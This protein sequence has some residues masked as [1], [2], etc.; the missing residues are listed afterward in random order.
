MQRV[1]ASRAASAGLAAVVLCLAAFSIFAAYTTRI[2]IDQAARAQALAQSYE[3]GIGV[4]QT[5][6]RLKLR[7]FLDPS[8]GSATRL[9]QAGHDMA[10]AVSQIAASGDQE[11]A[12]LA[13]D[14][15]ALH[16]DFLAATERLLGAM[17]AGDPEQAR[18]IDEN[19]AQPYFVAMQDRLTAAAEKRVAEG[20]EALAS[21]EVT[22]R[23]VMV[24]APLVFAIGFALLLG[25]WRILSQN[26]RATRKTYREI[27]QLSRLRAEFVSTVSHEFRTPLTGI[28]GF[29]EMMRD[30]VLPV[31]LMREYA[32]DINKDAKRLSR[33]MNDMLDL[34][35]LESGQMKIDVG[36]IDLNEILVATAATFSSHAATHPIE[37]RLAEGLPMLVADTERLTQVCTNLL[38][39]AIKYSPDGGIVEVRTTLEDHAVTLTIRDHGIGI[40][41]DQLDKVFER[42]SRIETAATQN[43]KGT[44]LGLPIV[45]QIVHLFDGKVWATSESGDGSAFHVRLPL[46]ASATLPSPRLAQ[47]PR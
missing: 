43:I 41:A 31:D 12:Q 42:Y 23:W 5:Q 7:F 1:G 33:L 18:Q 20:R 28:Q 27:E 38:T 19:L 24:A 17:A 44:G 4:F 45:R 13:R 16:D 21:L 30:E 46:A 14:M 47:L 34:D 11:D 40:P 9:E 22:S 35:Q 6:E 8:A 25:L 2:Q 36:P 15:L 10:E 32:G 3:D 29:S 37:L 26:E 39:N